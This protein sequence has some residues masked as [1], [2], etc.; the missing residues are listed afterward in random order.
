LVNGTLQCFFGSGQIAEVAVGDLAYVP[1]EPIVSAQPF[2]SLSDPGEVEDS[3]PP[4]VRERTAGGGS[5]SVLLDGGHDLPAGRRGVVGGFGDD[6]LDDLRVGG[7]L[8]E[9]VALVGRQI[10]YFMNELIGAPVAAN[11]YG[12]EQF[13]DAG[14]QPAHR[15]RH[16][17][18]PLSRS[19]SKVLVDRRQLVAGVPKLR[20]RLAPLGP[21]LDHQTAILNVLK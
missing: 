17:I 10:S 14:F 2:D 5:A 13:P 19:P 20:H 9:L 11:L 8:T 21:L 16:P 12:P 6:L 15:C 3:A 4:V 18:T 7:H 1:G